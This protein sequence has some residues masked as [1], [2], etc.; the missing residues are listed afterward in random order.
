MDRPSLRYGYAAAV[1]ALAATALS[2][3]GGCRSA[4]AT[5]LYL[6][7]G[8][9]VEAEFDELKGKKVAVVCRPLTSLT[10]TDANVAKDLAR[11]VDLLLKQNV[12]KVEMIDQQEVNQWLD[13]R[14]DLTDYAEIGGDEQLGAEM[15]VGIDLQSFTIYQSQVLYQGKA[16]V[17]LT[18]YDCTDDGEVVFR[19]ELPQSVYP[20]NAVVPTSEKQEREFRREYL[21]ILAD[22]IGRH[23]YAHDRHADCALDATVLD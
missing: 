22:Q 5:A 10:F 8:N 16:N 4:L 19:K 6:V 12:R 3:A 9:T 20:P 15:V 23:F 1:L 17:T 2:A 13:E 18:V 14:G 21:H 7:K 11:E